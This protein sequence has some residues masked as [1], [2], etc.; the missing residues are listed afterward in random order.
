MSAE[1][2]EKAGVFDCRDAFAATL[3]EMAATD[4]RICAVVNDSVGSTKLKAFSVRY[5]KRFV[6]VGI[7]EQNMVGASAGLAN[8]GMIPFCCGASCFLTARSMEQVKVDLGY[9]KNNVKLCGMSS[10]MAYGELGPTHHS[11]E[12]LA[13]TRV[14][15]NL[16]VI[17][18][19]DPQ[20][21][22]QVMRYSLEHQG[23]M[24][25]RISRMPV[26]KIHAPTDTF[27]LGKASMLHDGDDV[28]IIANGV[29][30]SRAVTAAKMLAEQGIHARV[31][32]MSS[33]K[34]IDSDAILKAAR[35]TRGIVTAE[36]ALQAGGLGGAVAEILARHHPAPMRMMGLPDVFAPTGTAEFLLEYFHLNAQGMIDAVLDLL[37]S[38]K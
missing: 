19:A 34:P 35:E 18:P 24:F 36:E 7:A 30:A 16:T 6:N 23:P 25:L 27:T 31:L 38:K 5:P 13:W 20:E 37:G 14:I 26:C 15:P 12:D 11:I 3:A 32:N 8:G 2:E 22:E 33:I 17:V 4:E 21:T 9:A 1:A 10:G 28:T 29:L